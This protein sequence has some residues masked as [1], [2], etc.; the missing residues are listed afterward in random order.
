MTA[1]INRFIIL[2]DFIFV[3]AN[4]LIS[5]DVYIREANK[6]IVVYRPSREFFTYKET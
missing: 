2:P 4:E 3:L 6:C 1:M 5:I